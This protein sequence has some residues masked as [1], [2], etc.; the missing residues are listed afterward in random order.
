MSEAEKELSCA[1]CGTLNCHKHASHYPKFCLTTNV[2]ESMLDESLECYKEEGLD[3]KIALFG[4][5]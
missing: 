4:P 1:E 3:R 5:G 2:E